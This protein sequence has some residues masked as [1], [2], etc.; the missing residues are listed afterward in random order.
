MSQKGNKA[1]QDF[2]ALKKDRAEIKAVKNIQL[3][4]QLAACGNDLDS[5]RQRIQELEKTNSELT[6]QLVELTRSKEK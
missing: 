5:A 3:I 1:I 4:N 2:K 6:K